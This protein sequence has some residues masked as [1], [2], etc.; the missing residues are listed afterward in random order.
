MKKHRILFFLSWLL[1]IMPQTSFA[2]NYLT[3]AYESSVRAGQMIKEQA[4]K[5]KKDSERLLK[6]IDCFQNKLGCSAVQLRTLDDVLWSLDQ[7]L[8]PL[9]KVS[10]ALETKIQK[11]RDF[12][13]TKLQELKAISRE[14]K[15]Q[16]TVTPKQ[17]IAL[18]SGAK[19]IAIAAVALVAIAA[20]VAV[21][22]GAKE[23]RG[24]KVSLEQVVR[25]T[26]IQKSSV[27]YAFLADV[28]KRDWQSVAAYLQAD[29]PTVRG[30][31]AADL[32]ISS[33]N[34]PDG[35][36]FLNEIRVKIIKKEGLQEA[37]AIAKIATV[38]Q[39]FPVSGAGTPDYDFVMY[40]LQ[41]KVAVVKDWLE[42][43]MPTLE[44]LKAGGSI[45]E[46]DLHYPQ[47][48]MLLAKIR[49]MVHAKELAADIKS[50]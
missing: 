3:S 39:S 34:N 42:R 33:H 23:Q 9:S 16:V 6:S 26:G 17:K 22:S 50:K 41:K 11:S 44:G 30:L 28:E 40:V 4:Q 43:D 32:L 27:D 46:E 12:I 8:R 14:A 38:R 47:R 48:T 1:V 37:D 18:V 35:T 36:R 10:A 25:D 45:I 5:V 49:Y 21:V 7:S 15:K 20:A 2:M 13:A 31:K 19:K 24:K 29:M